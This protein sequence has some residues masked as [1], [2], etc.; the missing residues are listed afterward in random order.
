MITVMKFK[1][2]CWLL[3]WQLLSWAM[4]NACIQSL[5]RAGDL[6]KLFSFLVSD[7]KDIFPAVTLGYCQLV[8]ISYSGIRSAKRKCAD[9][10]QSVQDNIIKE[11]YG[12]MILYLYACSYILYMLKISTYI[13]SSKDKKYIWA[14]FQHIKILLNIYM[15]KF[16]HTQQTRNIMG[17]FYIITQKNIILW[18]NF[19]IYSLLKNIYMYDNYLSTREVKV[20]TCPVSHMQVL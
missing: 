7:T 11:I 16:Q 8:S 17:K 18:A 4:Y 10:W 12:H 19:N 15:A 3:Q 13:C 20:Q 6:E 2:I 5:E 14:K 9:I 1:L